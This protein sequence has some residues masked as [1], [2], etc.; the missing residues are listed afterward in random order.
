MRISKINHMKFNPNLEQYYKVY[1]Q[2]EPTVH[3]VDLD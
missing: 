2:N 1:K 3:N